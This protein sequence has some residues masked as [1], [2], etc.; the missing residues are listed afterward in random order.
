M[1]VVCLLPA[2]PPSN[3]LSPIILE[4]HFNLL[5]TPPAIPFHLYQ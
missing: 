2:K 1:T 3:A 4:T 5:V